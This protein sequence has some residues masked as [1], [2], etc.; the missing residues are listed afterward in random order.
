MSEYFRRR[1]PPEDPLW[2]LWYSYA[3]RRKDWYMLIVQDDISMLTYPVYVEQFDSEY[4]ALAKHHL[5]NDQRVLFVY[6]TF[7]D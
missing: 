6:E 1:F 4:F 3:K 5:Q 2:A 7:G